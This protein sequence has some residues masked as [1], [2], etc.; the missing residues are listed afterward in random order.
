MRTLTAL[1]F[2]SF[3]ACAQV[4]LTEELARGATVRT[5]LTLALKGTMKFERNNRIEDAPLEASGQHI[6]LERFESATKSYRHYV[7][8][9]STTTVGVERG[10]K[11]LP[12]GKR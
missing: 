10:E 7:E 3:S 2:L 5:E 8:A 1:A 12:A 4:P 11:S 6:Y 9:K